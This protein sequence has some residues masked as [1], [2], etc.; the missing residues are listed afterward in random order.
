[1]IA[2]STR[3]T[4]DYELQEER[5]AEGATRFQLRPLS[6]RDRN[7]VEDL[8]GASVGTK[9]YP[10]GTVNTKVLRGGLVGWSALKDDK[11]VD[12]RFA[13]D[14]E[15]KVREELL[16]R[17]PSAACMEIATEILSH[18]TMTASDRKN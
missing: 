2:M 15:G 14:R 10:Y 8:I 11:G 1:M 13:V 4:W 7:E 5:G 17:L 16:E 9:G 3:E 6:L 12:V 18:S